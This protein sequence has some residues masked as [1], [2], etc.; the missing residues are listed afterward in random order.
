MLD[1]TG[2]EHEKLTDDDV[3]QLSEALLINDTFNGELFLNS[4]DLS[5]L[6]ALH[7]ASIFEKQNGHNVSKLILDGNNFTSKAGEYLGEAI[8]ANPG[9]PLRKISFTGI[10]LESIGLTRM[11][12]AV[13][14]NENI[15]RLD[16]GI[17]S[18]A[19][20]KQIATL[21]EPNKSLEE[22]SA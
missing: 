4:N 3:K 16:I 17:L 1:Y 9:Y 5:D 10:C 15:K 20:L 22:I 14:C 13:N 7:L 6:A 12:E 8:S 11:I 18:D 2:E 19:G 21:L